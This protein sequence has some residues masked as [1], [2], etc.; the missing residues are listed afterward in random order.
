MVVSTRSWL[1]YGAHIILDEMMW[2]VARSYVAFAMIA[3]PMVPILVLV[4]CLGPTSDMT[5]S[6][7][8]VFAV[9]LLG[10]CALIAFA[11]TALRIK[12][13][14]IHRPVIGT[15]V[16]MEGE[17]DPVCNPDSTRWFLFD[18]LPRVRLQTT[19]GWS[20][21]VYPGTRAVVWIRR[22]KDLSAPQTVQVAMADP[23]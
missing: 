22:G 4:V 11:T 14:A 10:P 15:V 13:Y 8:L 5:T 1:R 9:G 7:A 16:Y 17:A 12:Y 2:I 18:T 19:A 6:G 20:P 3:C 21:D 23:I